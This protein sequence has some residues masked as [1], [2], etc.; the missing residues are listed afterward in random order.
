[1]EDFLRGRFVGGGEEGGVGCAVGVSGVEGGGAEEGV[2]GG[3]V[4]EVRPYFWGGGVM[5]V[6]SMLV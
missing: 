1:M 3:S 2:D 6:L 4:E 5:G